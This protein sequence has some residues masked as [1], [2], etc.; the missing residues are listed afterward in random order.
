[1]STNHVLE[2]DRSDAGR[3]R[4]RTLEAE[5]LRAGQVRFRIESFA[6]TANNVTYAVAGDMLGYW[7][8]FP[9]GDPRWG[10]LPVGGV[11]AVTESAHDGIEV[12]RRYSGMFCMADEVVM[13][14][15]VTASGF[16]DVGPHRANHAAFYVGFADITDEPDELLDERL[17]LSGL[18]MTS[19]LIDDFLT[20][21]DHFGADRLVVTSASSK[22]ALAL[23]F[24]SRSRNVTVV[25]ATS[26][27]NLAFV[28]G[29]GLYDATV[30]YDEVT[31]L[32]PDTPTVLVDIAGNATVLAAIH[33]HFGDDLHHS[34]QVGATHWDAGGRR[35]SSGPRPEFFF[36]PG[37]VAART[38]DWGAGELQRRL[39][40][41]FR[42]FARD[43]ER[44]LEVR[45]GVGPS[46]AQST[47]HEL[48]SGRVPPEVGL[49][50]S[51]APE[52]RA[53]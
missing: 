41:G 19:F 2:I 48:L 7:D 44:W 45:H 9:T 37:R 22:T 1:M 21:Q 6:L 18:H 8:F 15:E 35:P 34:A 20:D 46:T 4:T 47:Y 5:P 38:A 29:L 17:L 42:A 40:A 10:V 31:S 43:A 16:R 25:G 50:L 52:E 13:A 12:G 51:M 36:A 30:T 26:S 33:D 49:I 39:E 24:C 32:D 11:A 14:A 27:R 28:E 23:A 53:P 3:S